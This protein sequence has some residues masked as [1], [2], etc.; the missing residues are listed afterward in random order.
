M[1]LI[2]EERPVIRETIRQGDS[3]GRAIFQLA[4]G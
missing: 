3:D 4:C 2:D 1:R